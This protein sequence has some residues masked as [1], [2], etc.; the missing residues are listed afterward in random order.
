MIALAFEQ[1]GVLE[2]R[3]MI[4]ATAWCSAVKEKEFS[5]HDNIL[6]KMISMQVMPAKRKTTAI[7]ATAY[8]MA[9]LNSF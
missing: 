5:K 7:V 8:C 2:Y 6:T 4:F 1:E 3:K 9:M